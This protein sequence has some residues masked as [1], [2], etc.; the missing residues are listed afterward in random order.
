MESHSL[1]Q[2]ILFILLRFSFGL[3]QKLFF[4]SFSHNVLRNFDLGIK[5]QEKGLDFNLG[6]GNSF[7]SDFVSI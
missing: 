5:I 1:E 2:P 3:Y 7:N 6:P 4:V